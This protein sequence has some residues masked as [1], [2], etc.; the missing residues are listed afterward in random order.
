MSNIQLVRDF[1]AAWNERDADGIASR[2]AP[3]AHY[4][5]VGYN[6]VTGRE[7]I[8]TAVGHFLAR[9]DKVDWRIEHI[10]ETA[11]GT[12]L[13]ERTDIFH[14]NGHEI[15]IILMGIFEVGDGLITAWRDY[16]DTVDYDKQRKA[17]GF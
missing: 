4:V 15:R 1:I 14:V 8:R 6:E 11:G 10:A 3:E 12:I 16:F 9:T 5:N 13:T 7:A 17:A 2:L